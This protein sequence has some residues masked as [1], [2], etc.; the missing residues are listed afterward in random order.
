MIKLSSVFAV[1]LYLSCAPA[2]RMRDRPA[3]YPVENSLTISDEDKSVNIPDIIQTTTDLGSFLKGYN[4]SV[5]AAKNEPIVGKVIDA[6]EAEYYRIF[7]D[8]QGF[9]TARFV[10]YG[11]S[12]LVEINTM[13][14]SVHDTQYKNIDPKIYKTLNDYIKNFK[15]IIEYPD[16]GRRFVSE[17]VIGWPLVTQREIEE[18][19][20]ILKDKRMLNITCCMSLIVPGSAYAGALIG[21]KVIGYAGS[22]DCGEMYNMIMIDPGIFWGVTSAGTLGGY[23]FNIERNKFNINETLIKKDILAFDQ[24]QN[25]ITIQD[26]RLEDRY[27]AK[28]IFGC[29]GL[30]LGCTGA[31]VTFYSLLAPY[32]FDM[33]STDFDDKAIYVPIVTLSIS[34][35]VL[36]TKFGIEQG[37]KRD[38][39]A[40]IEK[41]KQKRIKEHL[42]KTKR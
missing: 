34:E 12:V 14:D 13:I 31:V 15:S 22:G 2:I 4:D 11:D 21:K 16:Y 41:I 38:L 18:V 36:I 3:Y 33:T 17:H 1:L 24:Y 37:H 19:T 32:L 26:V 25:P 23:I 42:E 8:V 27:T 29:L 5:K 40:T 10:E 9:E 39:K 30:G 20:R 7:S 35:L 28:W 6:K